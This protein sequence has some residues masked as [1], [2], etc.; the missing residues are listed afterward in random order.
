MLDVGCSPRRFAA[1]SSAAP[2]LVWFRADLRLQDNPAWHA[3]LT[4]GAPV[5]PVFILDDAGEGTWQLGGASRWWLHHSLASL[6]AALEARGAQL[7]LR[8]G[9]TAS[10]LVELIRETGARSVYWNRRYEPAIV[11]R[12][13]ALKADLVARGI[14]AMS[15]NGA[16][17]FEPHT[18]QN[19]SGKPFQVFTPFWRHCQTKE[20]APVTPASRKPFTA[21][22]RWP[23]S[24]SLD[25]WKLLPERDWAAEFSTHWQPGEAGAQRRLK[26]FIAEVMDDYEDVRNEPARAGSSGLS[27]HLHFGE[28]SPRQV[29][30]AVHEAS[31]ASGVQPR[32]RGAFVFLTELGW[33]EFAHH[34]LFH[35]PETPTTALRPEY[36]DFPWE[37][38][39]AALRR[40]QRGL[41][42][43][44]IVDAGMRQLWRTGW[45]HNRVRMIVASFLV[46]HLLQPWQD[47]AAWF[48]DTLVDADLANNTLGWQ[49]SAG[50]GADAAPYFR[51]FNP[52]LQGEKF[53]SDGEYVRRWI[54]ELAPLGAKF[55]HKPWAAPADVLAAAKVRLGE[56]YPEPIIVPTLGRERALAAFQRLKN[57]RRASNPT[58]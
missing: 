23:R 25:T 1:M 11:A 21:P 49:W 34:L 3:A 53:D 14:E 7:I 45:M 36:R 41:T 5:V 42:G 20:V 39:A 6:A 33:R 43:Y 47:G 57:Q 28:I 16:L 4:S 32:S 58:S 15:F 55:I 40:W 29:W 2:I 35:F 37:P 56:N 54:P 52:V 44:P 22:P 18:I 26:R 24:E 9:D 27:P 13:S 46:K 31:R 10:A 48:W 50:C 30:W 51:V 12:D 19:Q 38:D 8:R 17:L